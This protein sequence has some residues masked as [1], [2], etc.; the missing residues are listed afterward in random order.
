M[1]TLVFVCQK[2]S[3]PKPYAC[4]QAYGFGTPLPRSPRSRGS[5]ACGAENSLVFARPSLA[6]PTAKQVACHVLARIGSGP[7]RAPQDKARLDV[8]VIRKIAQ[9]AARRCARD[10][11]G[12]TATGTMPHRDAAAHHNCA[13]G[14]PR[15]PHFRPRPV[16]DR[17][18]G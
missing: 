8:E 1:D 4:E 5:H 13:A 16:N 7:G 12:D 17:V 18:G 11:A 10:A 14:L 15:R 3:A 2:K 9:S 6:L